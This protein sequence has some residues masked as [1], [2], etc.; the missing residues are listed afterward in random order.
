MPADLVSPEHVQRCKLELSLS[1]WKKRNHWYSGL[2]TLKSGVQI[3]ALHYL[4]QCVPSRI[5]LGQHCAIV[6]ANAEISGPLCYT[7]GETVLE[8]FYLPGSNY[9]THPFKWNMTQSQ[10]VIKMSQKNPAINST[11]GWHIQYFTVT[12]NPTL[13]ITPHTHFPLAQHSWPRI[14]LCDCW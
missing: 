12:I 9:A 7:G 2:K 11:E 8:S 1:W 4:L 3:S 6:E 5:L 10:V 13:F 14:T